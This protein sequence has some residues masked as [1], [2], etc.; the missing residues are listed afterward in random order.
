MSHDLR[1]PLAGIKALVEALE[2]GLAGDAATVARYHQALGVEVD[3]LGSL[4]DDLF[5][6]SR[7]QAGVLQLEFERVSL[8]DLVSDA[9]AGATPVA[10]AKGVRLVGRLDGPPPEL[11]VSAPEVLRVLR[12]LLENAIRHTPP[13]GN[14]IVELG[15]DEAFAYVDVA[16]DGGGIADADLERVFDVAFR[17]DPARTPGDG[18]GLGLAIA[19]SLVEAHEGKI[20][21]RNDNG[22]ARFTVRLP[23]RPCPPADEGPRHRRRRVHRSPHRR[24]PLRRRSPGPRGRRPEP[25]GARWASVGSPAGRRVLVVR[26]A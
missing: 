2:D 23:A 17:N 26:R 20:S 12:N 6:L 24:A 10:A 5:E 22:G 3:R 15:E 9:I 8:G 1:T 18:A 14:V 19:K 4:I 13:D 7:T 25:R 11:Q 16:D 21:V